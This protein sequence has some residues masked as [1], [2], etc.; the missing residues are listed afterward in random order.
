MDRRKLCEMQSNG[1]GKPTEE[2]ESPVDET[3]NM[4]VWIRSTY[5]H[6]ESVGKAGGPPSKPKYYSV[7]DREAVL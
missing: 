2:G 1:V 4:A 6:E 3:L 5:G 7:T